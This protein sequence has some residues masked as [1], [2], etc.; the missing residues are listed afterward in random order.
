MFNV[1]GCAQ[2]VR[3][4]TQRSITAYK[5]GGEV[6]VTLYE[7]LR[8]VGGSQGALLDG[9]GVEEMSS[10]A[11]TIS[12]A[13]LRERACTLQDGKNTGRCVGKK[14]GHGMKLFIYTC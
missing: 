4:R 1:R 8:R 7:D 3:V 11:E 9:S 10:I 12:R 6:C 5:P 2:R 13:S 14:E